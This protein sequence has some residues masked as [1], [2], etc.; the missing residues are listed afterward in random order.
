MQIL[1]SV[2][3]AP[4]YEATEPA[5]D[6]DVTFAMSL[7][8]GTFDSYVKAAPPAEPPDCVSYNTR[9]AC[10]PSLACYKAGALDR[11]LVGISRWRALREEGKGRA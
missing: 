10:C 8:I 7:A 1:A 4:G 9:G 5:Q 11:V 3:E 2:G 6:L